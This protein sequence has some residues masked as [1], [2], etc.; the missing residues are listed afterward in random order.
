M[1]CMSLSKSISK[2]ITYTRLFS[3]SLKMASES[4]FEKNDGTYV[5]V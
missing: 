4:K 2:S 1:S 3:T 5:A